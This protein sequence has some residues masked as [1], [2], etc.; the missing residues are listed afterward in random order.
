MQDSPAVTPSR[1]WAGS[2]F[3]AITRLAFSR[4]SASYH[5]K[6]VRNAIGFEVS[7]MQS[8]NASKKTAL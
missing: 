5:T 1:V 2:A 8:A 6:A 7:A 3:A 4:V